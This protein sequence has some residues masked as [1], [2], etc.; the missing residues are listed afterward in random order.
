MGRLDFILV[1]DEILRYC[2]KESIL[3]GY[4][5]D[6]SMVSVNLQMFKHTTKPKLFWK[7]NNQLLK[8]ENFTKKVKE[9][10]AEV[11]REYEEP[12]PNAANDLDI[13]N[14]EY[15]SYVDDQLFLK[16]LLLK[17]R[18]LA[19]KHSTAKRKEAKVET[20]TLEKEIRNLEKANSYFCHLEKR[21]FQS[22]RMMS[23]LRDDHT[24]ITDATMITEEIKTFY[25]N[26]YK[27]KENTNLDGEFSTLLRNLP[28]LREE[29]A[30]KLTGDLTLREVSTALKNMKNNKSPGTDEFSLEFYKFFWTD[31][32]V[33]VVK[34]L[35][36]GF[37]KKLMSATQREGLMIPKGDKTRKPIQNWRTIK[38]L[39]V[40]YKLAPAAIANRVKSILTKLIHPDQCG[41]MAGRLTGDNTRLIYNVLFKVKQ[42]K[43]ESTSCLN[44]FR[45]SI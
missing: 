27:S 42:Q 19:I 3:P 32:G 22:K 40:V 12:R 31:L 25:T 33:F 24:E 1:S 17:T 6:H 16:I 15:K 13:T 44:R 39:N 41:F 38:L 10:I 26:L 37:T 18:E 8:G 29:E 21:N 28:K 20:E 14:N 23:L 34:A 2:H 36:E 43:K 9:Q 45:K 5:S 30:E 4:R 7:F 35:N 11:K